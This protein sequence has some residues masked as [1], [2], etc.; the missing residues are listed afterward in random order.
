METIKLLKENIVSN[1]DSVLTMIF[2][3]WQQKKKKKIDKW[4]CIKPK[5][6][7]H[8]KGDQQNENATYH[9][10]E[11]ICKSYIW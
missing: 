6:F 9:V 1:L 3:I 8:R 10:G 2:W 4:N 11:N 5:K 7:L